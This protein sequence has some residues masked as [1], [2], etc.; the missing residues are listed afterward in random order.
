MTTRPT[1][2]F[3]EALKS[4]LNKITVIN[5][6]SRRSEYWWTILAVW[7]VGW[8]FGLLGPI[9]YL[10]LKLAVIPITIRRLHD[11]GRS[12]WWYG[13][14]FLLIIGFFFY[15]FVDLIWAGLSMCDNHCDMD[16]VWLL[17][18]LLR[19]G[20]KFA[21]GGIVLLLYK[22]LLI[23]FLC[24][25]SDMHRNRYGDSPKYESNEELR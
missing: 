9:A 24:Q 10:L 13:V 23:V 14:Y 12:G 16:D 18:G 5:G 6:R 1:L 3:P 8:V 17:D 22:I 11:S 4:A 19:Y 21:F 2:E 25:D 15:M 20:V 7:I